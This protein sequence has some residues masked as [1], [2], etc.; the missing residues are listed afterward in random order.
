MMIMMMLQ[1]WRETILLW[2]FDLC[3][4]AIDDQ[5]IF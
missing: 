5:L 4:T 3:D 2:Q 1:W